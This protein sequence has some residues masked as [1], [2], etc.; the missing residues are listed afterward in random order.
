MLWTGL[1]LFSRK[2][3][4][5]MG[6]ILIEWASFHFLEILRY[7]E[8]FLTTTLRYVQL[9]VIIIP[10]FKTSDSL[11][12]VTKLFCHITPNFDSISV[13]AKAAV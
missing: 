6:K 4:Q 9:D 10:F 13:K 12:P 3:T 7:V 5:N 8:L 11:L 2:C 1:I